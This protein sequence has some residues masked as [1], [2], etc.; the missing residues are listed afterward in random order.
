ME[1]FSQ[2]IVHLRSSRRS[3]KTCKIKTLNLKILKIESSSCQCSMT[4]I[5]RK[6]E[7]QKDVFRIPNKSRITRKDSREDTE[8]FSA[9]K[10]KRR[11]MEHSVYTPEE[12][13]FDR[14]R[15]GGTF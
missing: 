12:L 15:D 9:L 3:K 7:I 10:T 11:G 14:H 8:H 13:G 1:Y 6:D 2:D 4:S 5:G